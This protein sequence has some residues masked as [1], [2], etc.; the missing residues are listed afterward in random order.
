MTLNETLLVSTIVAA[1]LTA[2]FVAARALRRKQQREE[3]V[4]RVLAENSAPLRGAEVSQ[5]VGTWGAY[6]TLADLEAR[7]LV[8]R[9]V[10]PPV[11]RTVYGKT[12]LIH[13]LTWYRLTEAG[14]AATDPST[15][16]G[17]VEG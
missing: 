16:E 15:G 8:E 12:Y 1:I 3:A 6:G 5:C 2:P 14:R 10:D 7:G 9:I 13:G 4:L 11:T 17:R